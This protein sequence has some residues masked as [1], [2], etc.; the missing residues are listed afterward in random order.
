[1][2]LKSIENKLC[3][4]M[5][6]KRKCKYNTIYKQNNCQFGKEVIVLLGSFLTYLKYTP[7]Y[8][9]DSN[10]CTDL[11]LKKKKNKNVKLEF[12]LEFF[13][14]YC[15]LCPCNILLRGQPYIL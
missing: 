6:I 13:Y 8:I 1:M 9:H 12:C 4:K 7:L 14:K 2:L 11:V 3:I 5:V 15:I 10:I